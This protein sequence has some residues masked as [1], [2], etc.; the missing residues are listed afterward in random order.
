MWRE[1]IEACWNVIRVGAKST[2]TPVDDFIVDIIDSNAAIMEMIITWV[3][4]RLSGKQ[5]IIAEKDQRMIM[6]AGLDPMTIFHLVNILF[7]LVKRF[8]K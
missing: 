8:R 6:E 7:E 1:L 3:E 5:A 2:A 4:T